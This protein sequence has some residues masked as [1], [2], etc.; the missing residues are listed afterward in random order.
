LLKGDT[1]TYQLGAMKPE[2]TV[3]ETVTADELAKQVALDKV[4]R[5]VLLDGDGDGLW[6]RWQVWTLS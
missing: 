1:L 6:I 3:E 5:W 2:T 4:S